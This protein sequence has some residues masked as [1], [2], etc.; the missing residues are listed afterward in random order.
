MS[1]AA[2][3]FGV[4][5]RLLLANA[6]VA[7]ASSALA[8]AGATSTYLSMS[9]SLAAQ[10]GRTWQKGQVCNLSLDGLSRRAAHL[11]F[12]RRLEPEHVDQVLTS[13]DEAARAASPEGCVRKALELDIQEADA[14]LRRYLQS[15]APYR[16]QIPGQ[17]PPARF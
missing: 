8:Q 5:A 13:Y 6:A 17:M 9:H 12:S 16:I 10:F 15:P 11:L 1:S 2:H 4:G 7:F 14:S 3:T